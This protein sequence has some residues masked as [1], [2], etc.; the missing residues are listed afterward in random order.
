MNGPTARKVALPLSFLG[1]GDYNTSLV[2]DNQDGTAA[3]TVLDAPLR[4]SNTLT[5]DLHSGGG[6]VARF[7]K[8]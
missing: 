6:F 8:R 5:I 3:E 2:R 4:S 1:N 7:S